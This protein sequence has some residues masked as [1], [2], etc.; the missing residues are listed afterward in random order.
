MTIEA[1]AWADGYKAS[2]VASATY[3]LN[4]SFNIAPQAGAAANATVQPGG[5]ATYS[6]IVT[7]IGSTSFPA[8]ITLTASGNPLGST[9]TF[10]P[11][12]VAA[13][14]GATNVSVS[15]KT[16]TTSACIVRARSNWSIALCLLFLP[17]IGRRRWRYW[18][19]QLS[20]R[21]RIV[22]GILLL[23][24]L[25]IAISGC[26]GT[27]INNNPGSGTVTPTPYAITVTGTSGGV[28]QTTTL[29]LTVQQEEIYPHAR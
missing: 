13:G 4:S 23:V 14:L 15:I 29:T 25:T 10:T 16:S 19:K 7:P 5:A 6:L 1:I 9:I 27:V 12:S 24:G 28:R 26:S 17:L 18:C 22:G 8:A 20:V 3:R 2:T 21:T 11:A